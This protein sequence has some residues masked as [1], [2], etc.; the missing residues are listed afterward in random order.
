MQILIPLTS[1]NRRR[2]TSRHAGCL[3]EATM[4]KQRR[5]KEMFLALI[6]YFKNASF[7]S[8]TLDL[9]MWTLEYMDFEL[10]RLSYF[11]CCATRLI[12]VTPY[13]ILCSG[14]GSLRLQWHCD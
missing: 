11:C 6:T 8:Y 9:Y 14:H 1:R 4:Y 10:A 12:T 13:Y 5:S 3:E 2:L 7:I